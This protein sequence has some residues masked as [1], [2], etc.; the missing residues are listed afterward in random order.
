MHIR[1]KTAYPLYLFLVLIVVKLVYI[2]IESSYNYDILNITTSSEF[3]RTMLESLNNKGHIIASVGFTLFVIPLLYILAKKSS[4][5]LTVLFLGVYSI[6]IFIAFYFLLNI[7][8]D[9]IVDKN[10]DKRY[11]AYYTN[12]VKYGM[13]NNIVY[14]NSFIDSSKLKKLNAQDKIT[15]SNI[16][17]LLY[18]DKELIA[19]FRAKGEAKVVELF[20]QKYNTNEYKKR[21]KE[22]KK[23]AKEI[24][25]QWLEFDKQREKLLKKLDN[26]NNKA[27]IKTA[28]SKMKNNLKKSYLKYNQAN[29]N[30][31]KKLQQALSL[32]ELN[33]MK[34][35]LNKFFRYQNHKKAQK[36]YRDKMIGSFGHYIE[37]KE[38]LD[39]QGKV[40]YSS[41][42]SVIK[43]E[44]SKNFKEQLHGLKANL[45][46]KDFFNT[47]YVKAQLAKELKARGILIPIDFNYSYSDFLKYYNLMVAK[48]TKEATDRFY[49]ELKEKIG[50]SDLKLNMKW[51]DY[52]YSSFLEQ[53]LKNAGVTEV[54]L[55]QSILVS[56]ELS[57]F[58][59][60]L[61][62]PT[63]YKMAKKKLIY[64]KEDFYTKSEIAKLGD[65]AIKLLYIPPIALFL[66]IL[67]MLLNS[68]TVVTML[69]KFLTNNKAIY[70]IVVVFMIA[71]V[72]FSP[73]VLNNKIESKVILQTE[74]KVL[75]NCFT[76]SNF[77]IQK[78]YSI[79][80]LGY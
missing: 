69:L 80:N 75:L 39:K 65:E 36:K 42:E 66:S 74:N 17:L 64:N 48:K 29:I 79:Q 32:K 73:F 9:T 45:S 33:S 21:Y 54:K 72:L 6:V 43:Q 68:I 38:W 3:S 10:K 55:V 34:K 51:K 70:N 56:K 31:E 67:A 78:N 71:I 22:F 40:T 19:K 4:Q 12:M 7:L 14:Y 46:P 30:Y 24:E 41:I 53:K 63:A 20:L 50:N 18:A 23:L 2:A 77:W 37:P 28:Y 13:L 44:A 49:K 62:M 58:R 26:L 52:I 61:Y 15:I 25:S 1:A 16:V 76:W 5:K 11:E 47:I 57:N 59:E 60:T 35:D 27:N 8:V